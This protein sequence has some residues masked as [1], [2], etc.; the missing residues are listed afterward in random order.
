MPWLLVAN[1][2]SLLLQR[3]AACNPGADLALLFPNMKCLEFQD[4]SL[5]VLQWWLFINFGI[6]LSKF[7]FIC[8]NKIVM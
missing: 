5:Q 2:S 8:A 7:L 6:L 1:V 4:I 3:S